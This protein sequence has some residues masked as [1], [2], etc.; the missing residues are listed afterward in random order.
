MKCMLSKYKVSDNLYKKIREN[1]CLDIQKTKTI[2]VIEN[3]FFQSIPKRTQ[4]PGFFQAR[5]RDSSATEDL[6]L[7]KLHTTVCPRSLD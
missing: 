3:I 7:L 1:V 6:I 4:N 5:L 2:Y